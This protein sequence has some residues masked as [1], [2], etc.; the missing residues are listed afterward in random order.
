MVNTFYA[1]VSA[2]VVGARG[3]L[4][5]PE[6]LV[7][8]GR[9]SSTKLKTII[10]QE[11]GRASPQ[12]KERLTKMLAVPSAVNSAVVTANMSARR[13]KRSVNRRMNEFPR[14]VVSRGPK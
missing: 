14:A 1:S 3:K 9:E 8:S 5:N 12:R 11:G 10:G 7:N 4:M 6:Q 2:G 13:L